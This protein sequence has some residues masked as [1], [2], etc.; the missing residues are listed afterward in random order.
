MAHIQTLGFRDKAD[1]LL[2][3]DVGKIKDTQLRSKAAK[4]R[5]LSNFSAC[6]VCI[7][8]LLLL[9]L[10]MQPGEGNSPHPLVLVGSGL[11]PVPSTCLHLTNVPTN[12][13]KGFSTFPGSGFPPRPWTKH[14]PLMCFC[15]QTGWTGR[16]GHSYHPSSQAHRWR[17]QG[18]T[19]G[20]WGHPPTVCTWA[21]PG[22]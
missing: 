2:I 9:F 21:S 20:S 13:S 22:H 8:Q 4:Q 16:S 1:F 12:N 7:F 19:R 15:V 14:T 5:S 18:G 10:K 11:A 17:M 3:K 6:S